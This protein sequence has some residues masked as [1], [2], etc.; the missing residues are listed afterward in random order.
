MVTLDSLNPANHP[1]GMESVQY[2]DSALTGSD[3]SR[4]E[5][6]SHCGVE[7]TA[8]KITCTGTNNSCRFPKEFRLCRES[9][10]DISSSFKLTCSEKNLRLIMLTDRLQFGSNRQRH[11]EIT[12]FAQY[13]D[14]RPAED[15]LAN[16]YES[17]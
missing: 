9:F 17:S 12:Y 1:L 10:K 13:I 14:L 8:V 5:V 15:K 3:T 4:F 7:I 2:I 16:P 11:Q 6:Q